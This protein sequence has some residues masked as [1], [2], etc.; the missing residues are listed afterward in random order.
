MS[1]IRCILNTSVTG[2]TDIYLTEYSFT[3]VLVLSQTEKI[4]AHLC[5]T[6]LI[7]RMC[8]WSVMNRLLL[9]MRSPSE[10]SA[11]T[12]VLLGFKGACDYTISA[13][14]NNPSRFR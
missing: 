2:T 7:Q 8:K 3:R 11:D 14:L 5:W 12:T 4:R 9:A 13:I 10:S 1:L 6:H